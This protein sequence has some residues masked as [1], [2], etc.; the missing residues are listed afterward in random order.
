MNSSLDSKLEK[1]LNLFWLRPENALFSTFKSK[2]YEQLKFESPSLDLSCGDGLFQAIHLGGTFEN[3]Y[4]YYES[5]NAN[6][7]SHEKFV[8]IYDQYDPS[9]EVKYTNK[10]KIKIDY[11]TDQKQALLNK[12]EK[13]DIFK[14]L[15]LH[16]NN[17]LPLPFNDNY[18]KTIYSNAIYWIDNVDKLVSEIF[19]ITQPNG[20]VGL[21][22]MT[23][24]LFQ[25]L[26]NL[27]EDFSEKGISILDR[28]RRA[29]MPGLKK[30]DEWK[31][32]FE[33]AGFKIEDVISVIPNKRIV[34]I[35]NI[36]LRPISH[37][38][39]KMSK[40][41]SLEERIKVKQEWVNIFYELFKPLL[42][43]KENIPIEKSGYIYFQ[44]KK[45]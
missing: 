7:F 2:A 14:N 5:T 40:S 34:D 27:E 16:D 44:L 30:Y 35:W 36:G 38:L 22:V 41:L 3:N 19:R 21:E 4:D 8:D 18:F 1:Y 12:A 10:P 9:Y 33:N 15:I 43:I 17:N 26:E 11:G 45:E 39:I 29:T 28:Q 23:P 31:N 20:T 42:Y 13:T 25:T 6:N 24:Y 37:L 32:I